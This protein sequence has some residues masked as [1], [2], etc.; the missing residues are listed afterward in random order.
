MENGGIYMS[1]YDHD[2]HP[3]ISILAILLLCLFVGSVLNDEYDKGYS[4]ASEYLEEEFR[5]E[6]DSAI[7]S[8]R[9][10]GYQEG[11]NDG[12]DDSCDDAYEEGYIDGFNDA[13]VE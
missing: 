12:Y 5:S 13:S 11:Y 3:V 1:S 2:S 10:E 9:T 6:L 4:D 8:A 7:E